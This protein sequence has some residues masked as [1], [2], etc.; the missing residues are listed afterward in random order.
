MLQYEQDIEKLKEENKKLKLQVEF[1]KEQL[2]YK[3]FGKPINEDN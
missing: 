3:T 1:L 2:F